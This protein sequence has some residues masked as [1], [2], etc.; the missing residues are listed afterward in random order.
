MS[1]VLRQ[2]EILKR[3]DLDQV[4]V[5][6]IKENK[7]AII[8]LNRDQMRKGEKGN[9][10]MRGYH[11]PAYLQSKREL[12]TY[13]AN[14]RADLFVTGDFQKAMDMRING[15]ELEIYSADEKA[16]KLIEGFGEDIFELNE[17]YQAQS[18]DITTPKFYKKIYAFSHR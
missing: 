13:F 1:E 5:D 3:I 9:G 4:A 15:K 18:S 2:L 14:P 10:P 16:P 11:N 12:P 6:V 8:D 17:N 7:E